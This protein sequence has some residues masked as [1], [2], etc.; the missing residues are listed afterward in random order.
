M[1]ESA[2]S[3]V[4][5][6]R[7]IKHSLLRRAWNGQ[8]SHSAAKLIA[9]MN[10]IHRRVQAAPPERVVDSLAR[11]CGIDPACQAV[12]YRLLGIEAALIDDREERAR[13]LLGLLQGTATPITAQRAG[14]SALIN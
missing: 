7:E 2:R 5:S 4:R 14:L 12:S 3:S 9:M 8:S 1:E 13:H 10:E 11:Q 6:A